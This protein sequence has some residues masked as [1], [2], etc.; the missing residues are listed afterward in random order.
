MRMAEVINVTLYEVFQYFGVNLD[1]MSD[2]PN[3]SL[4]LQKRR[5]RTFALRLGLRLI[6]VS[7]IVLFLSKNFMAYALAAVASSAFIYTLAVVLYRRNHDAADLLLTLGDL[8][9]LVAVVHLPSH[10]LGFEAL[11]PAWLI[12]V[13]VMN[14]RKETPLLLLVHSVGAWLVL[15]SHAPSTTMPLTYLFTQTLSISLASVIAFGLVREQRQH[16]TD[17]LTGVLARRA[18]VREL[19]A[20]MARCSGCSVAFIDLR[21]FKQINDS[22]GHSVGDEVLAVIAERLKRT[23]RSRDVIFRYGGDEFIVASDSGHLD[24]RLREVFCELVVSSIGPLRVD[25]RIGTLQANADTTLDHVL[26]EAD[27]RM[28]ADARA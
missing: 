19:Y 18:G 14:L 12:G 9:A 8:P 5:T 17:E 26:H 25:A 1:T 24:R 22:H 3:I 21:G 11:I 20:F 28:Y 2:L 4:G 15:V 6:I 16:R 7:T 13:M 23:V 10:E 27:R